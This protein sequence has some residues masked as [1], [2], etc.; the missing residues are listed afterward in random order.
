MNP[1]L[2]TRG[3]GNGA[4]SISDVTTSQ[5]CCVVLPTVSFRSCT[6]G[7]PVTSNATSM[8]SPR[9]MSTP[10]GDD[11]TLIRPP[12]ADFVGDKGSNSRPATFIK[13]RS[14]IEP[15]RGELSKYVARLS[16]GR[17]LITPSTNSARYVRCTL[18]NS[19]RTYR[20]ESDPAFRALPA[21]IA[22]GSHLSVADRLHEV[23]NQPEHRF[24][25]VAERTCRDSP[26]RL[27]EEN[28][29]QA[30]RFAKPTVRIVREVGIDI[31][32]RPQ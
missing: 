3:D 4:A 30:G 14:R 31:A 25:R 10:T 12:V 1:N 22:G 8:F 2:A 16:S 32:S 28:P 9:S 27:R 18:L 21:A 5:A 17:T 15:V 20:A 6:T 11:N 19:A 26:G 13:P 7:L 23:P 29:E 24:G